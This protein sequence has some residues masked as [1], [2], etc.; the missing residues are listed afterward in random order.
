MRL[1]TN[2]PAGPFE[3]LAHLG[4]D[5]VIGLLDQLDAIYRGERYRVSPWLLE[6][7]WAEAADTSS[8][9]I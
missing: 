9:A 2:Y 3:W 5:Y 7:R 1:G 4:S 8:G 6:R